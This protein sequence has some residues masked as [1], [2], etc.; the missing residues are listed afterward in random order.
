MRLLNL[1]PVALV[2]AL[3]SCGA[4]EISIS[5]SPSTATVSANGQQQFTASVG[6]A[7]NKAVLWWVDGGGTV[8]DAGLFTAPATA[9]T[10]L[11]TAISQA[12]PRHTS[13]ATVTVISP[14]TVS[15]ASII[16]APDGTQSFTA[17]VTATGDT[18]VTWSVQEGAAGGTITAGGVYTAP[19]TNGSYHVVAT[20]VADPALSGIAIVTVAPA[21]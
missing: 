15:P 16:V 8:T 1:I 14:V 10:S 12:D 11:V 19:S 20:S 13:T 17:V 2:V 9:G 3:L 7:G 6:N 21:I 4:G 5:I 18:A